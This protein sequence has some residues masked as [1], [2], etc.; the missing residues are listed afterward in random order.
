MHYGHVKVL[1]DNFAMTRLL[2]VYMSGSA[3]DFDTT[4][5]FNQESTSNS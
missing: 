2:A 4:D 3:F 5:L 1:P